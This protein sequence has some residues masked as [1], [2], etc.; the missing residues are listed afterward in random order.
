MRGLPASDLT[1]QELGSHDSQSHRKEA[2]QTENQQLSLDPLGKCGLRATAAPTIGET[3]QQ[4]ESEFIA[5]EASHRSDHF[6]PSHSW[7]AFSNPAKHTNRQN[8][9]QRRRAEPGSLPAS[10]MTVIL[11]LSNEKF[12]IP[13][14]NMLT[15]VMEK[16][17][18]M[19]EQMDNVTREM[20]IVRKNQ[21]EIKTKTQ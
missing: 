13:M 20:E 7:P 12:K 14:I 10:D 16:V 19:Q 8:T 3:G 4:R 6:T 11:K 21:T 18:N 15:A 5:A 9:A 17:E 2:E 1:C